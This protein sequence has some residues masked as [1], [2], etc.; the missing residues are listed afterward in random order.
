VPG[1]VYLAG[2]HINRKVTWWPKVRPFLDYLARSSFLLQQGKHVAD[3]LYYYG[4]GGFKFI[5]PRKDDPSY[6]RGYDYDWANT[7]VI[8]NRLAVKDGRLVL[9]DGMSYAALVLPDSDEIPP[10]VLARIERLVKEGATVAGP[11]PKRAPGLEGFPESDRTVRTI[12]S[13]LWHEGKGGI[14]A[15]PLK[16]TL[17]IE[18]DFTAPEPLDYVHRRDG[19]T[20]IYFVRNRTGRPVTRAMASFRV[21]RREP[22]LWDPVGGSVQIAPGYRVAGSRTEVPLSL[23]ANGSTFVVFRRAAS[24]SPPAWRDERPVRTFD[25]PSQGWTVRF[26]PGR[27]APAE[28]TAQSLG[29]WTGSSDAG[30]RYFSGTA[31]YRIA[32]DLPPDF[33]SARSRTALDLGSLW[34]IGEAWLNGKPLGIAWTAPFR[35]DCSEA[36]HP[37]RNELEVEVTNTWM[38]RLI[39]DALLPAGSPRLTK[40]NVTVSGTRPFRSLQPLPSGLFGPVRLV[41]LD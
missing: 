19:N 14:S 17:R 29:T 11:K 6:G 31:R 12:A 7:D 5:G 8:L 38:N 9:P 20:D 24:A 34:T 10:S 39:G 35:L 25:L 27:G 3:V 15:R 18:P 4:D 37:G 33:T 32:F 1:W 21:T 22:E 28:L 41:R 40:T 36:L 16:E 13:R 30:V 2:T 23:P 26:E